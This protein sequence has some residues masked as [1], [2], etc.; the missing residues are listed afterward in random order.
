M[1][2]LQY[3]VEQWEFGVLGH[4][5]TISGPSG[6]GKTSIVKALLAMS[7]DYA[8]VISHTTRKPRQNEEHGTDYFFVDN[9]V[10]GTLERSG[11][12]LDSRQIYGS[13]YGILKKEIL[14]II[15]LGLIAVTNLDPLGAIKLCK[16][17]PNSTS[18]FVLPPSLEELAIRLQ[19]RSAESECVIE[20]RLRSAEKEM[21]MQ[22]DFNFKIVNH[23]VQKSAE[24]I[25]ELTALSR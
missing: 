11:E 4:V 1:N 23:D 6:V 17:I 22:A 12:F 8:S 10:F 14:R 3:D 16:K 13:R 25:H 24:K 2:H 5:I 7:M 21:L 15:H 20:R 18:F 19:K 9:T